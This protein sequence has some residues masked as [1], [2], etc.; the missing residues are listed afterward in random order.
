MLDIKVKTPKMQFS[1]PIPYAFLSIGVSAISSKL[2]IRII[3]RKTKKYM[4]RRDPSYTLSPLDK[5]LL[6]Q[7]IHELKQH[8]GKEIVSVKAKDGTEV[9]I[10][11]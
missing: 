3:D 8:K 11:L 1:I 4:N 7:M 9:T 10:K 2:I 5:K 6:K